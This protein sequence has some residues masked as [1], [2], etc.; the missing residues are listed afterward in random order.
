MNIH[1]AQTAG[2]FANWPL[3]VDCLGWTLIHSLWQFSLAA[4][5]LGMALQ[6]ASSFSSRARY[7]LCLFALCAA[8]CLPVVTWF[9]LSGGASAALRPANAATGEAE[10]ALLRRVEFGPG[11]GESTASTT[12]RPSDARRSPIP[13]TVA[14]HTDSDGTWHERLEPWL[15][16]IVT[17]W[18]LGLIACST[19]LVLGWCTIRRLRA[20]A[21]SP[22]SD[23]LRGACSNMIARL[24][25][26]RSVRVLESSL[27]RVPVVFGYLRPIV[28]IPVAVASGFPADQIEVLVAHELAHI[29]R[30]DYLWN[31]L[32]TMIETIFFYHPAIWWISHQIRATREEC[33]D[34]VALSACGSPAAYAQALM[35]LEE[36]RNRVPAMALAA[37]GGS[38]VSRIR[39]IA[40]RDHDPR[41]GI[42]PLL[43]AAAVLALFGSATIPTQSADVPGR[44]AHSDRVV[45]VSQTKP[46]ESHSGGFRVTLPDGAVLQLTGINEYP[47]TG[48]AWWR[49]DGSPLPTSPGG[50]PR[51]G[52]QTP[53]IPGSLLLDFAVDIWRSKSAS[54]SVAS[55]EGAVASSS[56]SSTSDEEDKIHD[57]IRF[58]SKLR[59]DARA[60]F[61][62][63]YTGSD[64]KTVSQTLGQN[65]TSTG[66]GQAGVAWDQAFEE[67]GGAR[68]AAA[69][70][71]ANSE[72][73]VI[74]ID[75]EGRE[76][77]TFARGGG[78]GGNA[79]LLV[80]RFPGLAL[81]D[82]REFQFQTRPFRQIEFRN[83]S[84]HRGQQSHVEIFIDGKRY[85]PASPH[86]SIPP[87][88]RV[89]LSTDTK[90]AD[91]PGARALYNQMIDAL[92][93]A[94]SLSYVSS[95]Q[96]SSQNRPRLGR[97]L[98]LIPFN[99][100]LA[101]LVNLRRSGLSV[102]TL[103]F[104]Q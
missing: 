97:R 53:E 55:I 11:S 51:M 102:G 84:L 86:A 9:Q 60:T 29:R 74:A 13:A 50:A 43:A 39:R 1:F 76:H 17:A 57:R 54:A 14:T 21:I 69:W 94:K 36:L 65:T 31:L 70:D 87:A 8:I 22:V 95:Y 37:D 99:P 10:L 56:T 3:L 32:Q 68:I 16:G 62:M 47:S 80:S 28:L 20:A 42:G 30:H 52:F 67:R 34:D 44:S 78:S 12:A 90:I 45:N 83:V 100:I 27:V 4:V 38:L 5:L 48:K 92:H 46:E 77:L 89:G 75:R 103:G 61:T 91:E 18:L 26:R 85:V 93:R 64:W 71:V 7:A 72:V 2:S 19:R 24:G 25:L 66:F 88:R 58:V 73:R 41:P 33:C 15:P 81:A 82:I 98:S 6:F 35:S 40:G 101:I 79:H 49:P 23:Q 96:G 63:N 104:R 59:P